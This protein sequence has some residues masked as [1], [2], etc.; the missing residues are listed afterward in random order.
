MFVGRP[1]QAV[2]SLQTAWKG[3]PTEGL[4][5]HEQQFQTESS[6]VFAACRLRFWRTGIARPASRGGIKT[7]HTYGETDHMGFKVIN[8]KVYIH[9]LHATMLHL[10]GLN[11]PRLTWRN[12]GRDFWLTDM[13]GSVVKEILA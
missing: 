4:A 6:S 12:V 5:H 10:L 11:H 9:D 1:F 3:R 8:G 13:Y 2:S 7:G